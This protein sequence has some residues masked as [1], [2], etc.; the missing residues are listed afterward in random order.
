M[1]KEAARK[2]PRLDLNGLLLAAV[3]LLMITGAALAVALYVLPGE[4]LDVPETQ[5]AIRI[6]SEE[7]FMVGSSRV[8]NL[9]EEVILVVR[10]AEADY[11]ALQGISPADGCILRWDEESLRVVSPCTHAVYDLRGNVVR[12]LTREPLHRY[13]VYV[14]NG[15]VYVAT[16]SAAGG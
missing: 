2:N 16:R 3:V 5:P 10:R 8:Q 14:R 12:G 6:E 15:V 7:H 9:G 13:P 1:E 4:H 11:H